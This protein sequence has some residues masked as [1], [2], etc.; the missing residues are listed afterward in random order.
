VAVRFGVVEHAVGAGEGLDEAVVFQ[1][2][3]DVEG[4]EVFRVEAGEEHVDDDGDVDLVRLGLGRG[5]A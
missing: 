3:I 1:L 5:L 2:L 4:V